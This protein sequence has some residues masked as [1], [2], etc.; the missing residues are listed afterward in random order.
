MFERLAQQGIPWLDYH[1]LMKWGQVMQ[2]LDAPM[3]FNRE[4]WG[5]ADLELR[6]TV[7]RARED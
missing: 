7:V 4:N 2:H 3:I 5:L 6:E 1:E